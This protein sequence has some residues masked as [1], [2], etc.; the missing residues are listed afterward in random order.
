[1]YSMFYDCNSL[2]YLDLSNFNIQKVTDRNFMFYGCNSLIS[3]NLTNFN[4]Q[5]ITNIHFMFPGYS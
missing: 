1:M 4:N 5:N 3:I 2:A